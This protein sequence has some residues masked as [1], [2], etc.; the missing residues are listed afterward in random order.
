MPSLPPAAFFSIAAL[1][2]AGVLAMST[3]S[4]TTTRLP[5]AATLKARCFALRLGAL[6]GVLH[7][8]LHGGGKIFHLQAL[9]GGAGEAGNRYDCQKREERPL[10]WNLLR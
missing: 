2:A 7:R 9:G 4:S 8:L 10:H 5:L 3:S 6:E 1:A